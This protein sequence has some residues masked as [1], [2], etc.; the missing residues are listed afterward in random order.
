MN[1]KTLTIIIACVLAVAIVVTGVIIFLTKSFKEAN[2]TKDNSSA[3]TSSS[4]SSD[5]E[6]TV[7]TAPSKNESAASKPVSK[8]TVITV[9]SVSG[10]V[11]KKITVPVSIE[12][13]PGIMAMLLE[14]NYDNTVLKYKGYTPGDFLTNYQ[15][16]DQNGTLRFLNLEDKD[17]NKNGVLVNIEFEILKSTP[18]TEV[19]V[20]VAEDSIANQKEQLISAKGVNGSVTIK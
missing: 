14:F 6:N 13:N 5:D 11:G 9:G 2:P 10:S 18:K 3:V 12:G 19:K 7:S 15:F 1:K 8:N 17:V 4:T 20:N 16:N